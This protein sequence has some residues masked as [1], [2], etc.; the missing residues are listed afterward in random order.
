MDMR[1]LKNTEE[2]KCTDVARA[3]RRAGV[4]NEARRSPGLLQHI[5]PTEV[6]DSEVGVVLLGVTLLFLGSILWAEES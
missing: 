1:A 5:V 6:R 2:S 3:Y 4:P